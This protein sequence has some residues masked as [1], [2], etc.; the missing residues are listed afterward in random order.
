M[1]GAQGIDVPLKPVEVLRSMLALRD[2]NPDPLAKRLYAMA[3]PRLKSGSLL[4]FIVSRGAFSMEILSHELGVNKNTMYPLV[5]EL[6][7][8]GVLHNES[9]IDLG[10]PG[11]NAIMY[12]LDGVDPSLISEAHR[13][14]SEIKATPVGGSAVS[15]IRGLVELVVDDAIHANNSD[16]KKIPLVEIRRRFME[17][18][19]DLPQGLDKEIHRATKALGWSLSRR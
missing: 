18:H 14:H 5:R 1:G 6:V 3:N 4:R 7:S 15:S 8:M 11:I 19:G 10:M 12:V 9:E 13:F 17:Q 16:D 2:N